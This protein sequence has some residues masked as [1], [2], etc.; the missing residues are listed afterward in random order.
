ME[1]YAGFEP[2]VGEIIALRTFRIGP[3]SQLYPLFSDRPWSDGA[4][5]AICNRV[6]MPDETGEAPAHSAPADGC[7]CGFYAFGSPAAAG[8]YPHA[9]YVLAVVACWGQVIAGTRGIRAEQARIEALWFSTDVPAELIT[10]VRDRYPTTAVYADQAEMLA[11]HPPTMLDCYELEPET[12]ERAR[13]QLALRVATVAALVIGA[14]PR[15]VIWQ[16]TDV[17]AAWAVAVCFFIGA[18]I[19]R[20][21]AHHDLRRGGRTLLYVAVAL[22]LLAPFGGPSGLLFLRLPLLEVASVGL[23]HRL[24][25]NRE[26]RRFP[27]RIASLE[28]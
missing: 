16:H 27:A 23:I 24:R 28:A 9:R 14:L 12:P 6:P 5:A 19:I 21:R 1:D 7:T 26:A 4:N 11:A 13:V 18:A 22:W 15:S 8:E 17:L 20:A 25:L 3:D 10:G 2:Q